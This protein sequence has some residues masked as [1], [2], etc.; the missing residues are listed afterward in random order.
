MSS[1]TVE[2]ILL[3][4]LLRAR[5]STSGQVQAAP[6]AFWSKSNLDIFLKLVRSYWSKWPGNFSRCSLIKFGKYVF[7][8]KLCRL[9]QIKYVLFWI[10]SFLSNFFLCGIKSFVLYLLIFALSR[11]FYVDICFLSDRVFCVELNFFEL[12]RVE[13]FVSRLSQIST[14]SGSIQLVCW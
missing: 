12:C 7:C 8:I 5:K 9:S 1:N 4:L 10:V 6:P 13:F 11:V 3:S 2:G 14:E